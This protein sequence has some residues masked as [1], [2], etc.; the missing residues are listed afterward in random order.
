MSSRGKRGR[1]I[2]IHLAR[3]ESGYATL[4]AVLVLL[5][6]GALVITPILLYMNTG[7]EAGQTH[8]RRTDELYAADAGVN[9]ALWQLGPGKLELVLLT[10]GD[11]EE[12]NLPQINDKTVTV[13]ITAWDIPDPDSGE[14]PVYRIVSTATSPDLD[15]LDTEPPS[16]TTI[17]SYVSVSARLPDFFGNA[18]TSRQT[19]RLQPNTIV[20]GNVQV[21]SE[22]SLILR[23]GAQI[24]DG[25]PIYAEPENWPEPEDLSAYYWEDVDGHRFTGN[26]I[27][28]NGANPREEGPWYTDGSLAIDNT[29]KGAAATLK[30]TGTI[31]VKGN[32]EFL[33]PGEKCPYTIDLNG[34]TIYCEGNITL[35]SHRISVVG[36][37]AIIAVGDLNFQPDLRSGTHHIFLMSVVGTVML[38]PNGSFYGSVAGNADVQLQPGYFLDGTGGGGGWHFPPIFDTEI[39]TYN[40]YNYDKYGITASP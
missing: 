2:L 14:Q 12:F 38:R 36:T 40:I 1:G 37:G 9:Y 13:E 7:L 22:E 19:V 24:I 10:E 31:Y 15:P 6:L 8:E 25:Q 16:S 29:K 32:L 5:V 21:P 26:Y 11:S 4:I 30:L 18:I 27:N 33:Q 28:I 23:P 17:E 35:A 34:N 3:G 20:M 39:N